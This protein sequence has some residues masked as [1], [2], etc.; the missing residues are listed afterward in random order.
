MLTEVSRVESPQDIEAT[1]AL[2]REYLAAQV[3][4]YPDPGA[5]A[6]RFEAEVAE[7]HQR[8]EAPA[9][10]LFLARLE[11][12]EAG[13]VGFAALKDGF[14][15]LRRLYVREEY[16]GRAL[17]RALTEAVITG[18]RVAGYGGLRLDVHRSRLP[19]ISLYRALGFEEIDAYEYQGSGFDLVYF[20]LRL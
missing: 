7:L 10:G 18:A 5:V 14:A 11:G 9:G 3:Q 4:N 1:R 20:E 12:N 6:A 19:A 13:C 16:R 2:L 8:Y 15:E 17:G